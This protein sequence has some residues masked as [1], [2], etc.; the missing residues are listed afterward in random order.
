MDFRILGSLE[1]RDGDRQL[2]LGGSKR[3]AVLAFL[4]LHANEVVSNDRLTDQL[5]GDKVPRNAA[6]ALHTHV[7]RLRKELGPD[8]VATRAWGYVLRT[9]PGAIDLERFERLVANAEN[10]PA[11]ER[12]E[13]LR[14][15]LGLWRGGPLE[16]LAFEPSLGKDIA[17]LEELRLAVLENRIDA[18]LEAGNHTGIIGELETLIAENPLRERLRGQLILALYRS[19]RQAEALEVYRETRR[20]LADELGLEPSPELR[21]LERAILQ[22]DPALTPPTRTAERAEVWRRSPGRRRRLFGAAAALAL[23]VAGGLG[24]Y[25]ATRHE[26]RAHRI[27]AAPKPLRSVRRGPIIAPARSSRRTPESNNNRAPIAATRQATTR[28]M[29]HRA[30]R[31]KRAPTSTTQKTSGP[32]GPKPSGTS[33]TAPT[34][35]RTTTTHRVRIADSFSSDAFNGAIW[36]VTREGTGSD[37]GQSNGRL[38][39]NFPS[40]ATPGGAYN[41]VGGLYGTQCRFPGDFDARVDYTLVQWPAG[42]GVTTVL[43]A[44]FGPKNYGT[45]VTRSSSPQ[46][47][48]QYTS[49]LSPTTGA[50]AVTADLAGSL[51]ITRVDEV[52]TMYFRHDGKWHELDAEPVGG[53]AEIAIGAYSQAGD[54]QGKP[55]T[56]A[57]DNFVVTAS[58]AI[59][60][61][62]AEP[63]STDR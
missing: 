25:A 9:E 33:R 20:V 6:A 32:G 34:K 31:L 29:P 63:R 18:D 15:A 45:L 26:P 1:V 28:R 27:A 36:S 37:V 38:V 56:I 59:C 10:L 5:W 51:R 4:V 43:W 62:G 55:V 49:Y 50:G 61:P 30:G 48:E 58:K 21:E 39:W 7:S 53:A 13:K 60:P 42:N 35:T 3:R 2:D 12:A 22:Q 52:V 8:V 40:S 24:T 47:G 46:S 19:G 41:D 44:F 23:L 54:W 17:R 16:D 11:H 14:D 57:F